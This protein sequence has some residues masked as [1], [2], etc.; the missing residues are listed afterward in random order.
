MQTISETIVYGHLD[1]FS[2]LQLPDKHPF[3]KKSASPSI[4][5]VEMFGQRI[6]ER[7]REF[8]GRLR[9]N[10]KVDVVRHHGVRKNAGVISERSQ[11]HKI[12]EIASIVK[13]SDHDL[14]VRGHANME[15]ILHSNYYGLGLVANKCV[16]HLSFAN[17]TICPIPDTPEEHFSTP[18]PDLR[19]PQ[20]T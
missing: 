14:F 1:M 7:E 3:I 18:P 17:I 20:R 5:V 6:P 12:S 2:P 13:I 9:Q 15:K 8:L 11:C 19:E 4:D 10:D 16:S